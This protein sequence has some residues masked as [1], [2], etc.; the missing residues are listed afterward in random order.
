M[1]SSEPWCGVW[2]TFTR[3]PYGPVEGQQRCLLCSTV[4]QVRQEGG[5]KGGANDPNAVR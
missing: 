3:L 5:A 2:A 4:R 1:L